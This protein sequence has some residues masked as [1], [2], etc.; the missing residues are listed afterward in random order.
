M[1]C[2]AVINAANSALLECFQRC[3]SCVDN[4]VHSFSGVRLR[5]KC[6]EIMLAQRHEEETGTAKKVIFNAFTDKDL[7]LYQRLLENK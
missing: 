7:K 3:R 6:N 2:D 4:M 1:K 5:I